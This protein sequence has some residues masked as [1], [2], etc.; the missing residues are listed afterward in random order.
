MSTDEKLNVLRLAE[1][2]E[3]SKADVLKK[4]DI[5]ESTYYRW[6]RKFRRA[7]RLGLNDIT[8]RKGPVWNQLLESEQ[9]PSTRPLPPFREHRDGSCSERWLIRDV[10]KTVFP[11]LYN[12]TTPTR[13]S[14]LMFDLPYS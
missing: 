3:L 10:R 9:Q 5:P 12:P 8:S 7:G 6:Q 4:F 2:S 11:E 14:M 1:C 13:L